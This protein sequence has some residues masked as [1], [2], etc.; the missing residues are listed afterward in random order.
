M[1][2]SNDRICLVCYTNIEHRGPSA[3]YCEPCAKEI[4]K[5]Q[6]K[7]YTKKQAKR[8]KLFD[9]RKAY[10]KANRIGQYRNYGG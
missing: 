5:I 1:K 3:K 10:E 6:V 7:E 8:I 9:E 4:H 2:H